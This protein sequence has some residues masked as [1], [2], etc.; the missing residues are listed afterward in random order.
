MG[1]EKRGL[2]DSLSLS[3]FPFIDDWGRVRFC[4]FLRF[5]L[6]QVVVLPD[7]VPF[8]SHDRTREPARRCP[9]LQ[10]KLWFHIMAVEGPGTTFLPK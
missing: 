8:A 6:S 2:E 3:R 5:L 10:E 9:P 1:K 7:Q 4:V